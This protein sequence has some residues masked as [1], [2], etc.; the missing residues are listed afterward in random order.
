MKK[1]FLQYTSMIMLFLFSTGCSLWIEWSEDEESKPKEPMKE[2]KVPQKTEI[3]TSPIISHEKL[4]EVLTKTHQKNKRSKSFSY[5]IQGTQT[6]TNK[7]GLINKN[8]ILLTGNENRETEIIHLVGTIN[9]SRNYEAWKINDMIY[10]RMTSDWLKRDLVK[11][12][13]GPFDLFIML[14]KVLDSLENSDDKK[15]LALKEENENFVISASKQYLEHSSTTQKEISSY[16]RNG[17][18]TTLAE[19]NSSLKVNNVKIT[20]FSLDYTIR[21]H[22]YQYSNIKMTITYEYLLNNKVFSMQESIEKTHKGASKGNLKI[23]KEVV[24]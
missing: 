24:Q 10:E 13:R 21:Q 18:K 4:S 1:N 3:K 8:Q 17:L 9:T 12:K 19:S 20:D 11:A 14:N 6:L 7:D 15:G 22:D 23:P 16:I 5:S 2:Q